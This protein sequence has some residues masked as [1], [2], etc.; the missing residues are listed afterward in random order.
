MSWGTVSIASGVCSATVTI[1]GGLWSS[2]DGVKNDATKE[3]STAGSSGVGVTSERLS[4]SMDPAKVPPRT[5]RLAPSIASDRSPL[6]TYVGTCLAQFMS[7][8]AGE[9]EAT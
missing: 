9:Y 1:W 7:P 8:I 5:T 3:L 4:T 6:L 2:D